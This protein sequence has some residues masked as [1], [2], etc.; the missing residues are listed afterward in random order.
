MVQQTIKSSV[1]KLAFYNAAGYCASDGVVNDSKAREKLCGA[2][3][4][5]ALSK[6]KLRGLAAS[7]LGA[8]VIPDLTASSNRSLRRGVGILG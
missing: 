2:P 1:Y 3:S 5:G 8:S 6:P 4:V 7:T